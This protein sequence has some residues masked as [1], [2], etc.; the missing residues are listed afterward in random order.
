MLRTGRRSG[1]VVDARGSGMPLAAG[2]GVGMVVLA[3]VVYLLGGDP[4]AIINSGGTDAPSA[5]QVPPGQAPKDEASD[6]IAVVLADTEDTWNTVF[7]KELGKDYPE[8]KLVIFSGAVRSAC[9]V[10]QTAVGPFYCP[11]DQQV[12]ID[13]QF[14]QE[15]RDRFKAPGDFAQAYVIAHE[16]GHHVQTVLGIAERVTA[17]QQQSGRAEANALSVRM[18]LQADCYAG[19]WAHHAQRA[20]NV[21]EPGDI[22]EALGAASAIG[23]DKLQRETQGRVVPESFTHG[24]SAQRQEWFRRGFQS[25]SMQQCET[26]R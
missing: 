16:V 4:S 3:L 22:E 26:F 17:A 6:F 8:P 23:D 2:G 19:I 15:L 25:G 7:K 21:V 18:E 14:Y 9:G 1:N 20:R 13:L 5:Q 10:A 24:T 11:R 12:Y